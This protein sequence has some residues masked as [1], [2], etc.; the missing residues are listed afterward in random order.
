MK[1]TVEHLYKHYPKS[2]D[3]L[4]DINI[5]LD[6]VSCLGII[7]ASG[8]GKSTLLRQLAGIENPDGGSICINGI[9]PIAQKKLF[10]SKIGVVFQ[11]HNL[12]PHLSIYKNITLIL[13]KIQKQ[14]KAQAKQR[15]DA[16]LKQ[17]FIDH[18]KDKKP[19][20][21]SGGQA[22]RASIARALATDPQLIFLDEP[23][24]ALDPILTAEVLKAV[25]ELKNNGIEFIFVTHEIAFLKEFADCI[26]FMQNGQVCECGDISCLQ[27]PKTE[28]LKAFLG[29]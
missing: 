1:L 11:Q 4:R 16:V 3:V 5:H 12:F 6:E 9:S 25:T 22:Q 7:G 27:Q 19:N 15:A 10:Q 24:A 18:V 8:C 26:I 20:E 28:E 29:G 17:L 13:E 21:I 14:S 2:E 23:T